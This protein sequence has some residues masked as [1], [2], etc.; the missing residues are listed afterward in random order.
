MDFIG[1]KFL[2]IAPSTTVGNADVIRGMSANQ[3][4]LDKRDDTA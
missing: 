1:A 4:E 3:T 2:L